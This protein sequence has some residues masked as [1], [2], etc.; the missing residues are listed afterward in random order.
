MQGLC[1]PSALGAALS[2]ESGRDVDIGPADRWNG[3]LFTVKPKPKVAVLLS[4]P[5]VGFTDPITYI[6]NVIDALRA[7]GL[8]VYFLHESGPIWCRSLAA[9]FEFAGSKPDT[10][11]VLTIDWDSVFK[12]DDVERLI[13]IM[14]TRPELAGVFPVQASRGGEKPLVFIDK[15]DYSKQVTECTFGHFGCSVFRADL[16]RPH[17]ENSLPKPW[18]MFIPD[19]QGNENGDA[20]CDED[21]F[22]WRNLY[23]NG[24]R[25]AQANEVQIGH[26]VELVKWATPE[27]IRYQTLNNYVRTGKSPANIGLGDGSA[28]RTVKIPVEPTL[29]AVKWDIPDGL[30]INIGG[31]TAKDGWKIVNILDLPCVDYRANVLSLPLA[32]GECGEIYCSHVLEHLNYQ[33]N[34]DQQGEVGRALLE[35]W[36]VLKPGGRLRISVPDMK[37]LCRIMC[38]ENLD[39]AAR[40]HLMRMIYG[41]NKDEYDVH[42]TGFTQELLRNALAEVGF[43]NIRRVDSFNEFPDTSSMLFLG[44]RLSL[45]VECFKPIT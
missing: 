42:K 34:M 25:V 39:I 12:A 37:H 9:A 22:L 2:S 41:G 15:L 43:E 24:Y 17:D 38:E 45:N 33:G 40:F 3:R 8:E 31:E 6:Y 26:I 13:E 32:D 16:F 18:F 28:Y 29:P 11:Y 23:L 5:R 35:M 44:H 14:Q 20:R 4:A 27:G 36:R 1:D 21:I 7:R 30:K 10:D 19:P